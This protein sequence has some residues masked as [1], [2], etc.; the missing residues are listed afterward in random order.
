MTKNRNKVCNYTICERNLH[1]LLIGVN[2]TAVKF[3]AAKFLAIIDIVTKRCRSHF[4]WGILSVA[5][6]GI[7]GGG[8]NIWGPVDGGT[9]G[10][11]RGAK[12]RAGSWEKPRSTEA[13]V[14]AESTEFGTSDAV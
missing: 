12:R 1:N 9:E 10:P 11:E 8:A 2:S 4:L 7:T 13:V 6:P 14:T 5:S 3:L